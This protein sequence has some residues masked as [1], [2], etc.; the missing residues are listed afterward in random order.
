MMPM[1]DAVPSSTPSH[2]TTYLAVADC[3]ASMA[4]VSALGG[5]VVVPPMDSPPGRFAVVS[6]PFAVPFGIIALAG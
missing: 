3:D 5:S 4:K 2:W 1:S 6:D